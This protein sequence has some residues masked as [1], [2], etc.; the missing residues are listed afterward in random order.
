MPYINTHLLLQTASRAGYCVGAFNI[1]DYLTLEAVVRAAEERRSPVI[2]QTSSGTVRRYGPERLV[3]WTCSLAEASP[4]PVGLHLDHGTDPDLI[5]ACI[6][7]GY[8]SVMIDASAYPF[9][10]NVSRTRAVVEQ[11]HARGVSVEGEIGVTAGVEDEI[12]IHQDQAIYTTAEE[13]I[14]FQAQSG[15]D[16]LAVAI[17]TAHG[18]YLQAP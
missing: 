14:A 1:L 12:V 6:R 4:V 5:A 17:G 16:F 7:A 13:A 8:S 18:F 15:V 9:A 3:A 2:I 11:A 10:E